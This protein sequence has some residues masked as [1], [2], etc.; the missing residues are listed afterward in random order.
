MNDD[1]KSSLRAVLVSFGFIGILCAAPLVVAPLEPQPSQVIFDKASWI[2][3]NA[4][5]SNYEHNQ[6][7][8][9]KQVEVT[10]N[11]SCVVKTNCSGFIGYVLHTA[12]RAHFEVIRNTQPARSFPQA[13]IYAKFFAT[14]SQSVPYKGWLKIASTGQLRRGDLIAWQNPAVKGEGNTGHVMLVVEPPGPAE[15]RDGM[16]F[17]NVLVL[18][19]SSVIHFQP[20]IFP[21][22]MTARDGIGKGVVRLLVSE[23]DEPIGY[24]EGTFSNE[25]CKPIN[26]PT[27]TDS[28][29][30]ARP[31]PIE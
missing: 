12:A 27:L 25:K 26:R 19:C 18:D 6:L 23:N 14:L 17:I 5:F 1:L 20:E 24:W 10:K 30:F 21:R 15:E 9:L 28:V 11:Q 8:V 3:E 13:K 2:F 29:A 16:R 4:R 22:S 7:H 31:V